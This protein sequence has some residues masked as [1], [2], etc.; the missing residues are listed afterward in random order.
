MAADDLCGAAKTSWELSEY[1]D[2]GV[3]LRGGEVAQGRLDLDADELADSAQVTVG[4]VDLVEDPSSRTPRRA[5]PW[6]G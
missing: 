2:V 4:G 3:E 1:R 6:C 5:R